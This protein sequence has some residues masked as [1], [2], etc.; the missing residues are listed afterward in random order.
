MDSMYKPTTTL[1]GCE[2]FIL[3]VHDILTH[4]KNTCAV[5]GQ[6]LCMLVGTH[7]FSAD[8]P[9]LYKH[10]ADWVYVNATSAKNFQ[11]GCP[12]TWEMGV[13]YSI[14]TEW[15]FI[16]LEWFSCMSSVRSIAWTLEI[17]VFLLFPMAIHT[18]A[19]THLAQ[20]YLAAIIMCSLWCSCVHWQDT[21]I[22]KKLWRTNLKNRI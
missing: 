3:Q 19:A 6:M 11:I 17:K 14:H 15:P 9:L 8:Q 22:T 2:S 1:W 5:A 7:C 12:W 18:R 20:S 13:S 4:L 16:W 10:V 21:P